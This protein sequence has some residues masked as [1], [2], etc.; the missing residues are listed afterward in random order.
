MTSKITTMFPRPLSSKLSDAQVELVG[1]YTPI[2]PIE[3]LVH[4]WLAI[5]S[6]LVDEEKEVQHIEYAKNRLAC[7]EAAPVVACVQPR[8]MKSFKAEVTSLR[9]ALAAYAL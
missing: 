7:L 9:N 5:G 1:F 4:A 8:Q 2:K 3:H 6:A